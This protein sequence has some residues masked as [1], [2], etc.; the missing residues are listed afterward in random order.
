MNDVRAC[1]IVHRRRTSII[2]IMFVNNCPPQYKAQKRQLFLRKAALNQ[3]KYI[4]TNIYKGEF[5][6]NNKWICG[7]HVVLLNQLNMIQSFR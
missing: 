2:V 3:L 7:D 4:E 1:F 6:L 5:L